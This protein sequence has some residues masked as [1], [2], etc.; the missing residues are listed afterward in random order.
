MHCKLFFGGSLGQNNSV[1]SYLSQA[2][3]TPF[4]TVFVG[5]AKPILFH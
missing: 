1:K 4:L 3:V 5:F 2:I